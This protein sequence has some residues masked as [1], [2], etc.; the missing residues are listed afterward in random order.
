MLTSVFYVGLSRGARCPGRRAGGGDGQ[1][2]E[3]G[4]A[5]R[6]V[7]RWTGNNG[8]RARAGVP[9]LGEGL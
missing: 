7:E 4:S 1:D 2:K 8:A 5:G 9:D 3:R 6:G